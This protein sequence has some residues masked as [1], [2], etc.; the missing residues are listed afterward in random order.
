MSAER[1]RAGPEGRN[2][3]VLRPHRTQRV[4]SRHIRSAGAT[5]EDKVREPPYAEGELWG[6]VG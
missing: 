5:A 6:E 1:G 4:Q 2:C 3:L